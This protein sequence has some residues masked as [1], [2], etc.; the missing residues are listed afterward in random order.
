MR[1]RTNVRIMKLQTNVRGE[2]NMQNKQSYLSEISKSVKDNY[3]RFFE[4]TPHT[5]LKQMPTFQLNFFIDQALSR[6]FQVT[7]QFNDQ[8]PAATG[9][10]NRISG[11]RYLVTSSDGSM[12]RLFSL[13]EIQSIKRN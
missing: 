8:T 6:N 3:Y 11:D 1:F 4:I 9:I 13:G 5:Q 10:L 2:Q 12:N 7:I